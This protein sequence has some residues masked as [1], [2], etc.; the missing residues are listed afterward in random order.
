MEAIDLIKKEIDE[1]KRLIVDQIKSE[2][3]FSFEDEIKL[4]E[5]GLKKEV[6][7]YFEKE[8]DDLRIYAATSESSEK[9]KTKTVLLNKRN[10]FVFE[11]FEEVKNKLNEFCS[12]Q[13]YE[14]Y[15]IE[16]IKSLNIS[17]SCIFEISKRDEELFKSIFNKLSINNA[18]I[19]VDILIGGF[20]VLNNNI[21]YDLSF[22]SKLNDEKQNFQSFSN[23]GFERQ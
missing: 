12:S 15:L 2:V 21:E 3:A 11:L 10:E 7:T 4:Y 23:F 1:Q 17:D 16:K 18:Y 22:D 8:L 5:A 14:T 9:F 6:D 20:K 13:D 19:I